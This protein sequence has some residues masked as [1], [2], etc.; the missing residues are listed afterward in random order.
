[1]RDEREL[2][3]DEESERGGELEDLWY[4]LTP[5]AHTAAARRRPGAAMTLS[6]TSAARDLVDEHGAD[7]SGAS[8]SAVVVV[9]LLPLRVARSVGG[10]SGGQRRSAADEARGRRTMGLESA[11]SQPQ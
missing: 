9:M 8:G 7:A 11:S 6:P 4:Q 3:M 5:T 10:L 2:S 1:V